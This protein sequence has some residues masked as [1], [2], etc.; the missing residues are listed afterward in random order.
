MRRRTPT[1]YRPTVGATP[2]EVL[3]A[4]WN[5]GRYLR[6]TDP[7]A[8]WIDALTGAAYQDAVEAYHAGQ[9][10]EWSGDDRAAEDVLGL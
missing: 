6:P 9:S 7:R 3:R 8:N 4:A 2:A 1:T 10:A 5:C